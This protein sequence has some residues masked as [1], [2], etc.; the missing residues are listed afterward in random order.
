MSWKLVSR[1]PVL[2]GGPAAVLLQVAHPS[3]GAGVADHSTYGTDPFGRL[4]R[5]LLAMLSISFGSPER[6][7]EVL[8]QLRQV[9]RGI[10]GTRAD[11]IEYRALEP[12]LQL[13]VWATLIH[14]ALEVERRYVHELRPD[15]R[16]RYYLEST[17]LARAFRVPEAMI[18]RDLDAFDAYVADTARSLEVT[19]DARR[20]AR[21]VLRPHVWWAPRPLFVPVSWVTVDLLGDRL[22]REFGLPRLG[23]APRRVLRGTKRVTRTVL[24]RLPDALLANPLNRR[25][26]A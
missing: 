12:D 8:A 16:R 24:P 14:V 4:E 25:A 20:V 1:W 23:D 13:W 2:A 21:E 15:E 9:H 19:D 11:G 18:P 10:T 6:R 7:E 3:V 22:S 26:I 5:T 17:E